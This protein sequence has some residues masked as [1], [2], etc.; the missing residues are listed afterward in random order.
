ML[1]PVLCDIVLSA[2]NGARRGPCWIVKAR[3]AVDHSS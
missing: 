2:W 3:S 1:L